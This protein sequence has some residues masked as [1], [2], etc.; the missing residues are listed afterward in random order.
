MK[1]SLLC[2][3]TCTR[4]QTVLPSTIKVLFPR[5]KNEDVLCLLTVSGT[6]HPT[7]CRR[8]SQRCK[9]LTRPSQSCLQLLKWA[10]RSQVQTQRISTLSSNTLSSLGHGVHPLFPGAFPPCSIYYISYSSD[11]IWKVPVLDKGAQHQHYWSGL[12]IIK[13]HGAPRSPF[14]KLLSRFN[15][16]LSSLTN[17]KLQDTVTTAALFPGTASPPAGSS[18]IISTSSTLSNEQMVEWINQRYIR[19][20]FLREKLAQT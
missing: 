15:D 12:P 9:L 10:C 18:P 17:N 2:P 13:A 7:T 14:C 16:M 5:T 1:S 8:E 20:T 4:T 3:L 6:P 11:L 19:Q